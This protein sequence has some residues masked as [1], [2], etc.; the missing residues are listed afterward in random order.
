M[1]K[2][3][4]DG[5]IGLTTKLQGASTVVGLRRSKNAKQRMSRRKQRKQQ[6]KRS[7]RIQRRVNR[8]T[9]WQKIHREVLPRR[10]RVAQLKKEALKDPVA[11]EFARD[12]A[13]CRGNPWR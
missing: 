7:Q 4:F 8:E 6:E 10:T 5:Y 12:F 3:I 11:E 9:L 2:N 13:Y 1:T